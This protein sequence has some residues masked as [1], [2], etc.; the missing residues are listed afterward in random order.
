MLVQDDNSSTVDDLEKEFFEKFERRNWTFNY[1]IPGLGKWG[2]IRVNPVSFTFSVI[3]IWG[4]AVRTP[5]CC[6]VLPCVCYVQLACLLLGAVCASLRNASCYC[7]C[8]LAC[9]TF[10]RV[11][12]MKLRSI[13]PP[14]AP[15]HVAEPV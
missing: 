14:W 7:I 1:K 5:A 3:L 6:S 15:E 8:Y 13:P 12:R 2:E 10:C 11:D 4:F 9:A